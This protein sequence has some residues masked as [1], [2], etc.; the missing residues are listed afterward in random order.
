MHYI[1]RM[2]VAILPSALGRYSPGKMHRLWI[3]Y[4]GPCGQ[5]VQGH[6]KYLCHSEGAR[7]VPGRHV[8]SLIGPL[9]VDSPTAAEEYLDGKQGWRSLNQISSV[10]LSLQWRHNKRY[11]VSNHWR[12]DCLLNQA[13]VKEKNQGSVSQ[14]FV[15]GIH[16]LPVEF[17]HKGSVTRKMFPF[18]DV[19]MYPVFFQN[20]KQ[21]SRS[22]STSI[23]SAWLW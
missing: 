8:P 12:L 20:S 14:P 16:R 13:Q 4:K 1:S 5:R 3:L 10:L 2:V 21:I 15:R 9:C 22:F 6:V 17:P 23:P 11:G 18:D 7:S 19:I